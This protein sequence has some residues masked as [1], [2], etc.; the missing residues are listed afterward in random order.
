MSLIPAGCLYRHFGS[1]ELQSLNFRLYTDLTGRAFYSCL[2]WPSIVSRSLSSDFHC[3]V[4][5]SEHLNDRLGNVWRSSEDL[6]GL[7]KILKLLREK[8]QDR[9]VISQLPPWGIHFDPILDCL[10]GANH[11]EPPIEFKI[12][13]AMC[14]YELIE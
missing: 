1:S 11:F 10:F 12:K 8:T 3:C 13:L 14:T 6:E 7:K 2:R 9:E 5:L 4:Q